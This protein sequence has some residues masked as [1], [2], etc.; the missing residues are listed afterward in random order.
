MSLSFD[1]KGESL[2]FE[3]R[4]KPRSSRDKVIG[5]RDGVLHCSVTAPPEKGRANKALFELLGDYF[6]FPKS[7]FEL[8]AGATSKNKRVC[9]L[10]P[11]S[12]RVKQ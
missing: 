7:A 5:I 10:A 1:S 11:Y 8:T 6:G 2:V 12:R 9:I 3:V 4:L